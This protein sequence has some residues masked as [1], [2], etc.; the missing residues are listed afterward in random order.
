MAP[1]TAVVGDAPFVA[2]AENVLF[3]PPQK[4]R[5][6][7]I[8]DAVG[9]HVNVTK[10][11]PA[12]L[13][14]VIK[15]GVIVKVSASYWRGFT[16][17]TMD[18]VG[19]EA[20]DAARLLVAKQTVNLGRKL[21]IPPEFKKAMDTAAG[22]G[23]AALYRSAFRT[24]HGYWVPTSR[25]AQFKTDFSRAKAQFNEAIKR[26]ANNRAKVIEWV[27][28]QFRPLA[29]KSWKAIGTTWAEEAGIEHTEA[30]PEIFIEQYVEGL[31]ALLPPNDEI[32]DAF[33]TYDMTVL[34]APDSALANEYATGDAALNAELRSHLESEG[35]TLIT[36]FLV[37]AQQ[38][39]AENL[40]A[41]VQNVQERL[42][43]YPSDKDKV[44]GKIV[45]GILKKISDVKALNVLNDGTI[46]K[47][48]EDLEQF[49]SAHREV[50]GVKEKV[51]ISPDD[52]R[53]QMEVTAKRLAAFIKD[54]SPA[55][56]SFENLD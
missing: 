22:Q 27:E 10:R 7:R 45:S 28:L 16:P 33:L 24:D 13:A 3:N 9:E 18:D 35:K 36:N 14:A 17:L 11:S 51:I 52:M 4:D 43:G 54:E 34:M 15:D 48:L 1:P 12:D 21:L 5:V 44:H 31:V 38:G 6:S 39:L 42:S 8:E 50:S 40:S 2:T 37:S 30:A 25:F 47:T 53:K 46:N 32:L 19:F 20:T 29:A 41:M 49:I 56:S 23:R 55:A 26:I